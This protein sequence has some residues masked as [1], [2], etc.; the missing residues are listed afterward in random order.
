MQ[1]DHSN[2]I[3][4][5]EEAR[6]SL[7]KFYDGIHAALQMDKPSWQAQTLS[8][9]AQF[10]DRALQAAL[11][12]V[13]MSPRAFKLGD[14]YEHLKFMVQDLENNSM[15]PVENLKEAVMA[16]Y[17]SLTHALNK[18]KELQRGY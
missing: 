17:T 5:I 4:S 6:A 8:S 7:E 15:P 13:R 3:R 11:P 9:T 2:L 16:L 14:N 18:L 10:L 1:R 12:A